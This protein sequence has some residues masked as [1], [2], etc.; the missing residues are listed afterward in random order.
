MHYICLCMYIETL[1][2]EFIEKYLKAKHDLGSEKLRLLKILFFGP[3][4]AGKT[5]LFSVLL[6]QD[7]K[8]LRQ[9]TGVLDRKLVQFKV[10]VQRDTTKS[11]SQ[12][13]VISIDEEILR[14]R[15]AIENNIEERTKKETDKD[16][17]E[18]QKW[19][20]SLAYD[21]SKPNMN[22]DEK[23]QTAVD[24]ISTDQSEISENES[25]I[26]KMK[27]QEQF[28][29]NDTLIA[30]YDSGGQPEIFDVMPAL[31]TITTGN[32]MVFDMSKDLNL[33]LDSNFFKEGNHWR[34]SHSK[35]HYTTAQLL[36]TA[37]ASIQSCAIP[38]SSRSATN[39]S[40]KNS[41]LLVVGTHLD[42]CGDTED[43]VFE[44]LLE[45]E[46]IICN[47]ILPEC[48]NLS[49][50]ERQKSEITRIIHPIANKCDEDNIKAVED[51]KKAAQEIRTT[52]ENM[53][54]ID[55]VGH[56]IP[57]SWLLF[58]YEIKL[59]SKGPCILRSDCDEIAEKSY[60]RQEDIDDVL[61]FFHELGVLLY[62]KEKLNHVV[63]SDPQWLFNQLTKIIELKYNPSYDAKK[64][65]KK[66]IF[67][68]KFLAEIYGKEF[69]S[70]SVIKYEDFITLF[71]H[72]NIMA[73]LSDTP[74]QYFMPALLDPAPT[75]TSESVDKA[76]GS[77]VFS[78]LII[79]FKDGL[80]P[81]GAFC[82]LITLSVQ[83]NKTWKLQNNVTYKNLVVFQIESNK[84]Y[85]ICFDK[86][87]C[88]AIEIH[89]KELLPNNHQVICCTLYESL[90]EV[91]N[92]IHL[93]GKFEFGF[94]CENCQAGENFAGVQVQQPCFPENLL[95]DVCQHNPRMTYDQLVWFIPSKITD[96][97]NAKVSTNLFI[98]RYIT[99]Q[100]LM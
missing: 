29:V 89:Q 41:Q 85:L 92:K 57:I 14:L 11:I 98:L 23:L 44:R 54:N 90:K 72:L 64:S 91:G 75:G 77:K 33:P 19:L 59:Q 28:T 65:I 8:S 78:T 50:I 13:K 39:I 10:A 76:Y 38:H 66:G 26:F 93:N 48:S 99:E 97:L 1:S 43:Q 12:W 58:Q 68:K 71:V 86:I 15:Y 88:I 32:V 36:K 31:A 27:L 17:P 30:C 79:R 51:R 24:S 53:S 45:T 62:Y 5:T 74:E 35:T 56:E 67:K 69:D 21:D 82:C 87:N 70:N 63:I 84:E 16:I 47:K 34:S 81:R 94:L 42:L 2:K 96:I 40:A 83:N 3:A 49:V 9:S 22:I 80:I 7:L 95:C 100:S 46:K 37:L 52:I 4:G 73:K 55:S 18:I 25:D 61:F 60:I 6:Q 20:N